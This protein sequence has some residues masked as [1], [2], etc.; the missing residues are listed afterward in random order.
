LQ[1]GFDG[2]KIEQVG[3]D[4]LMR[5]RV[6]RING[7][8]ADGRYRDDV[9]GDNAFAKDALSNRRSRRKSAPS[10]CGRPCL[11]GGAQ[12]SGRFSRLLRKVFRHEFLRCDRGD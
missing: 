12:A 6:L 11:L 5:L 8:A 9:V 1:L 4:D 7:R 10:F 2:L 3:M